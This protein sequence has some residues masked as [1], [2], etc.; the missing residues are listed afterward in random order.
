MLFIEFAKYLDKLETTS[1]RLEITDI[2]SDLIKDLS[3]NEAAQAIHLTLGQLKAP[4]ESQK[5]N[6]AD[7]MMVKAVS[8]AYQLDESEV[9][10]SYNTLGDL[11][12]VIINIKTQNKSTGETIDTVYTALLDIA[13]IEG[14][15]SQ[16]KKLNKLSELLNKLDPLSAKY[17]TRIILGTTRLGFTALTIIDALVVYLNG[18]KD[19]QLKTDIEFKYNVHPDIGLIVAKIIDKGLA[20]IQDIK[21]EPGVPLMPQKPQRLGTTEET[22]EKM[23]GTVWAEFKL[24]GTRVQLHMDRK[25]K[26]HIP[27]TETPLFGENMEDKI[28]VKTFTRN[29]DETTHQFPDIIQAAKEYINA[30]SVILDG[31]A[32]GYNKETGEYLPFQETIQRKRKHGIEDAVTEIPLKYLVFD[33]LFYNGNETITK[34]L[35]ERRKLLNKLIKKNDIILANDNLLTTDPSA[36]E[37]YFMEAKNKKLEGLVVKNPDS[38]YQAGAGLF[39]G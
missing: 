4:F 32:I 37:D 3:T 2:L 27:L 36:L 14:K 8:Q 22:L 31:E 10:E 7:K 11:G 17:V 5:F 19:K 23:N 28:F 6:I 30:D 34:P 39:L 29:L 24:D 12:D 35:I 16:E 25:K 15:G 26:L 9:Q 1:K 20:G 33:I 21:M 13:Q 38:E 18:N